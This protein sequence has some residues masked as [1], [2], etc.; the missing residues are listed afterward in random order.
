MLATLLLNDVVSLRTQTQK[1]R[2]DFHRVFLFGPPEGI[3]PHATVCYRLACAR[4]PRALQPSPERLQFAIRQ[5]ALVRIPIYCLDKTK[6]NS[7]P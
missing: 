1:G 6:N 5:T 3:F 4:C 7:P 2:H